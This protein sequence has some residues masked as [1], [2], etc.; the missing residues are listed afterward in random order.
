[1]IMRMNLV[2]LLRSC[3]I[4]LTLERIG[5]RLK[6]MLCSL[7]GLNCWIILWFLRKGFWLL[8]I[9]MGKVIRS[10]KDGVMMFIWYRQ[11]ISLILV[12]SFW[13]KEISLYWLISICMEFRWLMLLNLKWI[14]L[15]HIVM[16]HIIDSQLQ[17]FLSILWKTFPIL[18]WMI[19]KVRLSFR[20]IIKGLHLK[21]GQYIH[22]TVEE[23]FMHSH[24]NIQLDCQMESVILKRYR[25]WM[26]YLWLMCMIVRES[27]SNKGWGKI[28]WWRLVGRIEILVVVHLIWKEVNKRS[29][30]LIKEEYGR[31]C[32]HL[33]WIHMEKR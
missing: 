25:V 2:R 29:F 8:W 32:W 26:E 28:R 7:L 20:W 16:K 13:R 12:E 27:N 18:F 4:L 10:W 33:R 22:Q 30:H 11:M 17:S 5:L 24:Y 1:M 6:I 23:M 9:L 14:Y 21:W 19:V 15:C 31:V 3:I